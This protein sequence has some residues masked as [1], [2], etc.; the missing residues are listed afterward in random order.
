MSK[1]SESLRNRL[2]HIT[3]YKA[4]F[5]K[6][7]DGFVENTLPKDELYRKIEAQFGSKGKK[8]QSGA[9][10]LLKSPEKGADDPVLPVVDVSKR[11]QLALKLAQLDAKKELELIEK[12]KEADHQTYI[13]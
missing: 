10:K 12:V 7:F 8:V 11:D 9:D 1:Y 4:D 5:L 3:D 6:A 2:G 13:S